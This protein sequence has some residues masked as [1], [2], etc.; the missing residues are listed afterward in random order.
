M[1]LSGGGFIKNGG[2]V[3]INYVYL[4]NVTASGGANF[5]ANNTT[6]FGGNTGWNINTPASQTLY[7]VGNSGNWTD[8][9]HW[10][11]TSGGNSSN[12]I[13]SIY[14]NVVFDS[15]SFTGAGQSVTVNAQAYCRNMTWT[16]G[17]PNPTLAGN[18]PLDIYGSYT[19]T[20]SMNLT[21]TG[22]VT[23]K[24]NSGNSTITTAGKIVRS[25]IT[26]NGI[27]GAWTLQDSLVTYN[28]GTTITLTS[29]ALNTNSQYVFANQLYSAGSGVRALSLG[30]STL[31]LTSTSSTYDAWQLSASNMS[32][33]AGSSLIRLT[34]SGN[35][36]FSGGGLQYH[37]LEFTNASGTG[38]I[39]S[40]NN[41]FNDVSFAGNGDLNGNQ[42]YHDL[43]FATSKTY[44]LSGNQTLTG[45][46]TA[47][48]TCAVPM[49]LSGGGFIKNGGSVT[50]NYVYL[51]NVTASGGANFTANNTTDFG[52]NTGWNINTPASQT[53]YWVGNSGNWT[54]PLHWS[55]TSGGNSSNCIPSIYDNVVFD[56]NS[57]TGAG[58][59]VTVNAQAYCRN[60]TWTAGLPNP[61]LAGNQP[62]DIYGS[63]TLTQSMNLTHTGLVT[64]K[65]NSG[66]STITTAGKIVRSS[67]TFNG[68]GGAWTL[69]DSLVTY[70]TGT[71]IT[72]TSGALNTNSQYVFANQLYSAGSG[73]RALSL[74]SSTLVLTS[75]SS[76]Y[77]AWQLSASN[78]SFSAGVLT[79]P[80]HW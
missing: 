61:T 1:P 80:P 37:N 49:P 42:S 55:T 25:S 56:S 58:Q 47:N 14:D 52:G 31:V 45:T 59:S 35:P 19:L 7:W 43:T 12:C 10:S 78:M 17:L 70:N 29:G 11:T 3:T 57:F 71:T 72:L 9:L 63:Y 74:G 54:D 4:T 21:H 79:D 66:N 60:M 53:L 16:A 27:G 65:S 36:S 33:S 68:I 15:N 76:T 5:T 39:N 22:L 50:I 34:G 6:D 44:T 24:S 67:I 8:P 48:G 69:Q 13:P 23:F 2:S 32:F 38:F 26:F 62:L 28:T 46:L 18:Q 40:A 51:T 77:D 64:F 20:Q 73:V 41:S 30:S 75:T